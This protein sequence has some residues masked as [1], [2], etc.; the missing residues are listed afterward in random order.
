MHQLWQEAQEVAGRF[1]R[2]DPKSAVEQVKARVQAPVKAKRALPQRIAFNVVPQI[3][4]FMPDGFTKEELKM[5]QESRK[6]LELPELPVSATC[7]RVPVYLA[8]SESVT[9]EFERPIS[10]AAARALLSRSSGVEVIDEPAKGR[11]PMPIVQG[12]QDVVAVG[13]IRQ[14]PDW[15]NILHFWVVGDNLRKGA[16]TNAVQI[17]ELLIGKCRG[18]D[19]R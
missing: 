3:D 13:R 16:A 17:A 4:V 2:Y 5:R 7:V 11:Y 14:D 6:I 8:H 10:A 19:V 15:P 12:G 1:G 18:S 9:A